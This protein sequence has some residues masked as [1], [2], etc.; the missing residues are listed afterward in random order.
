VRLSDRVVLITG[1]G[2]GIGRATAVAC[3]AEGAQV[4]LVDI[5]ADGLETTAA[6]IGRPEACLAVPADVTDARAV[7][8]AVAAACDR[9]GTIHAVVHSAYWTDP[10]PLLETSEAAM[11]RTWSVIVKGL[12]Y[13]ARG[14]LPRMREHGGVLVPIASIHALVGF[15]SFFAYQVAKAALLGF[16]RSVAVDYGPAVRAVALCPG[17]VDTPALQDATPAVRAEITARAPLKRV[18]SAEEVAATVVYLLS[19]A[20]AFMTGTALVLDGGWTAV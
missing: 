20:A 4:V 14:V 19:D 9:F 5:R 18:A 16:V 7:D 13:V 6:A 17:A 12:Y 1:A 15:E 11:D 3:V 2:S 10:K 8:G